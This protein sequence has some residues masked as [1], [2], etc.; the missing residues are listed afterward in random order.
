MTRPPLSRAADRRSALSA[1]HALRARSDRIR[2]ARI[3]GLEA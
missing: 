3:L 2:K 1:A